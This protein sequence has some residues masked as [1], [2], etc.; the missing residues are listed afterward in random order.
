MAKQKVTE[1]ERVVMTIGTHRIESDDYNCVLKKFVTRT[2]RKSGNKYDDWEIVGY[3]NTLES[4]LTK[5]FNLK[6]LSKVSS[7]KSFL[8]ETKKAKE[9]IIKSVQEAFPSGSGVSKVKGKK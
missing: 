1:E 7:A 9:E 5:L 8:S 2:D 4:A 6:V 3:Y